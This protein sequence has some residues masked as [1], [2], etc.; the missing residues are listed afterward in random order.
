MNLAI[1]GL[2]YV[3]CVSLGCL[4]HFGNKVIGVDIEEEKVNLINKG[5]P[6]VFEKDLG[7][8]IKNGNANKRIRATV[9]YKEGIT[10]SDVGIICVGTP[11]S[12]NGKLDLSHIFD[13]GR[14]IGETLRI[15][16]SFYTIIVRSTVMPGTNIKLG[17][18]IEEISGKKCDVDFGV[19][20]NPEFLREG[21]AVND[22]FHPPKIVLGSN[23]MKALQISRKIYKEIS[24]PIY[25]VDP[26]IAEMIKY[27]NNSFHALKVSF[28]N[29]VGNICKALNIDSHI[30]MDLFCKDKILNLSSYYLKPGQPY[31][32]SCLTKDLKALLSLANELNVD[33][34][35]IGSIGKSNEKQIDRIY[36]LIS[37]KGRKNIGIF[38]L[39]FKEGTDD[40]RNSP[41]LNI[42]KRLV[43]NGFKV[44]IYDRKINYKNLIGTNK[45]ILAEF[46]AG[47]KKIINNSFDEVIKFSEVAVICN[48]EREFLKILKIPNINI[49]DLVRIKKNLD[50]YEKYDGICW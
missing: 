6:T 17:K 27:I 25:I 23:S 35:L 22:F 20:S 33:T 42:V 49:V 10:N 36:N 31:G 30:V 26:E 9:D 19:V 4:S 46:L 29:E 41:V 45:L 28:A 34:P 11:S 1:F 16:N 21:S 32:G 5:K 40:V 15:K 24:A 13:V 3:G 44:K 38:G 7:L 48:R 37:S 14:Q 39:S 2:G 18:V 43:E 47:T 8:I 12:L 50:G